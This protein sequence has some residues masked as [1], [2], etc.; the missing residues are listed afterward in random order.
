MGQ[1]SD[2][3]TT[4]DGAKYRINEDGSIDVISGDYKNSLEPQVFVAYTYI[5]DLGIT[6]GK[7]VVTDTELLFRV[8][9]I[10]RMYFFGR[11]VLYRIPINSIYGICSEPEGINVMDF[12]Q[13][14][15][16]FGT[17]FSNQVTSALNRRNPNIVQLVRGKEEQS[18]GW[19]CLVFLLPLITSVFALLVVC[20]HF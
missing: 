20:S 5:E 14:T 1:D 7:L 4:E 10:V 15:I 9:G 3:L 6:Q 8:S 19:G 13:N 16:G 17:D 18:S 12:N 11:K 2:I